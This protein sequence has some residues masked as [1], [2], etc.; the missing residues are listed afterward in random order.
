MSWLLI[1]ESLKKAGCEIRSAE[2]D[3]LL[4]R[5][6]RRAHLGGVRPR[7]DARVANATMATAHHPIMTL[8]R[9]SKLIIGKANEWQ[10]LAAVDRELLRRR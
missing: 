4:I 9:W 10:S 7:Q 3:H 1:G 2:A 8:L 6:D 5:I